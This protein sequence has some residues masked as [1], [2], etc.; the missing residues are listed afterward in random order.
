MLLQSVEETKN[1]LLVTEQVTVEI[2]G[3]AKP[4][5]VAERLTLYLF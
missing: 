5:C 4:G 3:G 2:E 1:G